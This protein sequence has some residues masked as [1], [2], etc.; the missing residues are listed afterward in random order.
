MI[1]RRKI[2]IFLNKNNNSKYIKLI[3]F[4]LSKNT[5][6]NIKNGKNIKNKTIRNNN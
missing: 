5:K 4:L 6:K 2:K 1:N 3:K